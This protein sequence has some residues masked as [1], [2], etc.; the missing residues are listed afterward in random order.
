MKPKLFLGI[1]LLFTIFYQLFFKNIKEGVCNYEDGTVV[2]S[3]GRVI[4]RSSASC[5]ESGIY[6][7]SS[8]L[9]EVERKLNELETIAKKTKN[10]VNQQNNKI[11]KNFI[12]A[13]RMGNAVASDDNQEEAEEGAHCEKYPDACVDQKPYPKKPSADKVKNLMN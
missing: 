11:F 7:N 12:G 10:S 3:N 9:S 5:Q 13:I 2:D 4:K 6:T 8:N 1:L